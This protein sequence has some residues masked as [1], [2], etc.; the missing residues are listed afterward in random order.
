[1]ES[2]FQDV[3]YALRRLKSSRTFTIAVAITLAI[4]IGGTTATFSVADAALRPLPF[5]QADRLVR[6]REITPQGEPF[7]FSEPDYRDFFRASHALSAIAAIK[8]LRLTLAGAGD[9]RAVEAS[10][11]TS[12][13]FPML[14][15][16]PE[17][18]R[19]FGVDDD[20]D[21]RAA[22]VAMLSDVFWRQR[23]AADPG[24]V[25]RVIRL[26][27]APVTVVGVLPAA[28]AFPPGDIWV[29]LAPSAQAD[30]TDKWLDAIGR[31]APGATIGDARAEIANTASALAREHAELQGWSAQVSPIGDWLVQPA[32]RRMVWV[33]LGAVGVLLALACANI[34]G[35]LMTRAVE[36]QAEIGVRVA[37][38]AERHR[39]LRQLL[40][41]SLVLAVLGGVLG[42]LAAF[43]IL[44]VWSSLIGTLLPPGRAA[45]IDVR[46]MALTTIVVLVATVAFGLIPALHGAN[47]DLVSALK[48]AG[49]QGS[50][51]GRRWTGVFAA[52]Q[53][54]LAMLLLVGSFLLMDSFAR[55]SSVNAG[56]DAAGV[57][58]IPL[59]LPDRAYSEERRQAFFDQAVA[60]LGAVPGVEAVAATATNPFREWGFANDVTPEDRAATAPPSGFT[61]AGWRSVTPGFFKT[62]RIPIRRG[63][64]FTANDRD[65]TPGVVVISESL[66]RRLW[67]GA[68]AIGRRIYWGGVGGRTREVVGV[69]ADI[70]DVRLDA[71]PAPMV[72]LAY[73]QLPLPGMTL[74]VRSTPGA[75]GVADAARRQIGAIDPSIPVAEIASVDGNRREAISAP[76]FRALLVG[77]F[78]GVALL[79]SAVGL[80]GV[81]AFSVTQ[82]AREIAIRLAV[83]ARP[84]QVTAIFFRR[85]L[86][87]TAAG[88]AAGLFAAWALAGVLR[89]LLFEVDARDPRLFAL[90]AMVLTA[91]ALFASYL[92]ARRASR[93]DPAAA[94]T[95]EQR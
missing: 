91:I 44:D 12:S 31:L 26:D 52:V 7:T 47:A 8:P 85:G 84:D 75:V 42:V 6:L 1:M 61:Q 71:P 40:T 86:A 53:V 39:V 92:P 95:R 81:I 59:S 38:G 93:L 9:A 94:L 24:I 57:L 82:R 19:I 70:R 11:V 41:E 64:E 80:Y 89:S 66:A 30:R 22:A 67:P 32:T 87:L 69:A 60:S 29:P 50:P 73:S 13:L 5:P 25:G 34:A 51:G 43:W 35:L 55:L 58:A 20:R 76:R 2:L 68:D 88:A 54:A 49:R 78:G 28:A 27:G 65:G 48:P 90:A 17:A 23:F 83:G 15:I 46:V 62:L 63:R 77:L 45:S 74:L 37:L 16:R 56:F 72:Y 10:A 79:L 18:G 3:R 14:G 33:L 36:R 21:G 4:G